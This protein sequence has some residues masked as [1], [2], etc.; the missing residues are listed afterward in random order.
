MEGAMRRKTA[1]C[2]CAARTVAPGSEA[3]ASHPPTV[4]LREDQLSSGVNDWIAKLFSPEHIDSTVDALTSAGDIGRVLDRAN[5][6][7]L[8]ALYDALRLTI[9]YDHRTRVAEV[10]ITPTPRVD[11]VSEEERAP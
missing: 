5:Q 4:H 10:S 1:F 2:R 9:D 11:S 3:A 8:A 6:A 7:D